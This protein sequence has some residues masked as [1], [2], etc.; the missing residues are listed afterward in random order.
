MRR[1]LRPAL[2][3]QSPLRFGSSFVGESATV[4][5][6]ALI[7]N[8]ALK[9]LEFLIGE[10][11]TEGSHPAVP[12][13]ILRGRT[14]FAWHQG[15][16]FLIMRS[17]VDEPRFPSG[18]AIIGSDDVAGTFAMVYFD[19]RGISRVLEVEVGD[20]TVTWRRNDPHLSQSLTIHLDGDRLVSTGRMSEQGGPWA[21][22]LSQVFERASG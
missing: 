5:A 3:E 10:W 9:P 11:R 16:A 21:D 8:P 19:E 22:D 6:E 20:R 14:S 18:L 13:K 1:A 17:E 7:P 2:Q 15:G 4:G 12:G